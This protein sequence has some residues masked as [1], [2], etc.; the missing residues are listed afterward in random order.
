M[1]A[2]PYFLS[3]TSSACPS[4]LYVIN[5]AKPVLPVDRC[6]D[7]FSQPLDDGVDGAA[8]DNERRRQQHVVTPRAIDRSSHRI[9][10]QSARHSFTLDPRIHFALRIER[11]LGPTVRYN[12]EALKQ[13]AAAHVADQRMIA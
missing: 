7:G 8:V 13:P 11:F 1:L 2:R 5:A 10:H 4:T 3:E 9:N 6:I 12:L